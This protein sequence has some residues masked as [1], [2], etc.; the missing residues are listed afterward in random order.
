[1]SKIDVKL[2][3]GSI[4][5]EGDGSFVNSCREALNGV[6]TNGIQQSLAQAGGDMTFVAAQ[7]APEGA[8]EEGTPK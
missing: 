4:L 3:N 6:I 2:P 5:I 7:P 1:M 8:P